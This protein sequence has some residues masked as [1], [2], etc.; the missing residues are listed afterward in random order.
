MHMAYTI[1]TID[2]DALMRASIVN[3][4]K[5]ER[6]FSVIEAAGGKDGLSLALSKHPDL[7]LLDIAMSDLDGLAVLRQLRQDV[8]G[9]TALVIL[10][11]SLTVSDMIMEEVATQEPAFTLRKDECSIADVVGKVKEALKIGSL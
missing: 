8:W 4:F 10:L 9:K 6:D 11:T 3:A 1:L 7:I 5:A 2:D